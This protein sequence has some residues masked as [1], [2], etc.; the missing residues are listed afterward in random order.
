M[1]EFENWPVTVL[2]EVSIPN[3]RVNVDQIVS[4]DRVCEA[5]QYFPLRCFFGINEK[6]VLSE[7][8][9]GL[10]CGTLFESVEAMCEID[11]EETFSERHATRA[12]FL[13]GAFF[14]TVS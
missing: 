1:L 5:F 6:K 3:R 11:D 9:N 12:V 7:K 13:R 8:G 2:V 10:N 14:H 4:G